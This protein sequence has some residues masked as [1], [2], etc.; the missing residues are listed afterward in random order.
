MKVE[1]AVPAA[2]QRFFCADCHA[3]LGY[4]YFPPSFQVVEDDQPVRMPFPVALIHVCG[5]EG[6]HGHHGPFEHQIVAYGAFG[7]PG[8]S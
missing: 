6:G 7:A 4:E 2:I 8:M 3:F 1:R 5:C